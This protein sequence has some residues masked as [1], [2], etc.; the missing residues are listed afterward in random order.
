MWWVLGMIVISFIIYLINKDYKEEV[1]TNVTSKGGMHEKY[2][3][4]VDYFIMN[5]S[6]RI[7]TMNRDTLIITASTTVMSFDYINGYLEI[8]LKGVV[9]IIGQYSNRWRYRD[10]YPQEKMIEEIENYMEWLLQKISNLAD[11]NLD[12]Y[13]NNQ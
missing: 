13:F 4:V 2:R 6:A 10:G 1:R 9:P 12:K 5:L 7:T 11:K 3:T 8:N